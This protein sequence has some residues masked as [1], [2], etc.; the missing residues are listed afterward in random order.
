MRRR[1]A[2]LAGVL[3]GAGLLVAVP[4]AAHA[5]PVDPQARVLTAKLGS[6]GERLF[7]RY[8]FTCPP[9]GQSSF[10]AAT[11]TQA[12][13]GDVDVALEFL[14]VSC[15]GAPQRASLVVPVREGHFEEGKTLIETVLNQ[16]NEPASWRADEAT[17]ASLRYGQRVAPTRITANSLAGLRA[18]SPEPLDAEIRI[19]RAR[20]IAHGA[21]VKVVY[22]A[23]CP[24]N[25]FTYVFS[26]VRQE[27]GPEAVDARGTLSAF[28]TGLDTRQKLVA[29]V[30]LTGGAPFVPGTATVSGV[31]NNCGDQHGCFRAE[32][33]QVVP[34]QPAPSSRKRV[35]LGTG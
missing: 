11:A 6:G 5:A 1:A 28:C 29:I 12:S 10:L 4:G 25:Y 21:A 35:T 19:V 30:T 8:E 34:L 14:E 13:Q 2:I 24:Q 18:T 15:T 33:E 3:L 7:L 23:S 20:L 26:E 27:G 22:R 17:V 9:S 32:D 31:L 16:D